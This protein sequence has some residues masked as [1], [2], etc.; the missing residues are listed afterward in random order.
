M[1]II[2]SETQ[3]N[4]GLTNYCFNKTES[5][6]ELRT[7]GPRTGATLSLA[8]PLLHCFYLLPEGSR[9]NVI[10]L[11]RDTVDIVTISEIIKTSNPSEAEIR[12]GFS[13]ANCLRKHYTQTFPAA[14]Y[15]SSQ[16]ITRKTIKEAN[17]IY[18]RHY[19]TSVSCSPPKLCNLWQRSVADV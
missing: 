13:P 3:K 5:S 9:G 15:C 8:Y 17:I 6:S 4:A 16:K 11:V 2:T 1:R 14:T 18:T 10:M 12:L 19:N 7:P